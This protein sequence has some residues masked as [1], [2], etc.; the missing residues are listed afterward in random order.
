[1]K[2]AWSGYSGQ[3]PDHALALWKRTFTLWDSAV[4]EGLRIREVAKMRKRTGFTLIELLVVVAIIAL[5]VAILVPSL[6]TARALAKEVVC[7]SNLRQIGYALLM[8]ANDYQG[9]APTMGE[10]GDTITDPER[11]W[12]RVLMPYLMEKLPE[13]ADPDNPDYDPDLYLQRALGYGWFSCS[14]DPDPADYVNYDV[15]ITNGFY[16]INYYAV[17][18]F[19]IQ[20]GPAVLAQLP[21]GTLVIGDSSEWHIWTPG[22]N[23]WTFDVDT[24]GDG[25]DDSNRDLWWWGTAPQQR[26][27]CFRPRHPNG[28]N[29]LFPDGHAGPV[30]FDQWLTNYDGIWGP[31]PR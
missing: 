16:G 20:G 7:A 25:R 10:G 23:G 22:P 26:Y 15:D 8:Y 4:P 27:N 21:S 13:G 30:T 24:D 5:L 12:N 19:E 14:E 3:H 17:S 28:G 18:A 6:Q 1:M 11:A 9:R 31:W 29:V 2:M